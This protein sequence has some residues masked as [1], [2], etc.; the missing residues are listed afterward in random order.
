MCYWGVL[1]VNYGFPKMGR[2]GGFISGFGFTT[3]WGL[4]DYDFYG[5]FFFRHWLFS[6]LCFEGEIEREMGREN[7]GGGVFCFLLT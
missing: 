5:F 1:N 3:V 7:N 6:Y 4:H 2:G